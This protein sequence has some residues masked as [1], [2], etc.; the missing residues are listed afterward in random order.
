MEHWFLP[1]VILTPR[2]DLALARNILVVTTGGEGRAADISWVE[3]D[4][5]HPSTLR[6]VVVS[7]S[8]GHV[9]LFATPWTVACQAPPSM[10]F[11]RQEYWNGCHFLLQGIFL[12][13]GL[14]PGL[15]CCRQTLYC[16]SHQVIMCVCV[17]DVQLCPTVCN[18]TDCNL[19]GSSVH[20]IL[21]ARIL[22]WVAIPFSPNLS[23]THLFFSFCEI[24]RLYLGNKSGI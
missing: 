13:Q 16:L 9:R 5:K 24:S 2:G 11:S 18:P 22:G 8:L 19:P 20:G 7:Q 23:Q 21:Q 3:N 6:I 14:N 10:G 12:T 4:A 1:G 15:P 17:L